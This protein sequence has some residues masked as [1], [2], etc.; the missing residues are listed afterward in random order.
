MYKFYKIEFPKKRREKI[1]G[2]NF[3]L[4]SSL[5]PRVFPVFLHAIQHS[6]RN[7]Q[8]SCAKKTILHT[9]LILLQEISKKYHNY[10]AHPMHTDRRHPPTSVPHASKHSTWQNQAPGPLQYMQASSNS[11][12]QK[13]H[14]KQQPAST[15]TPQAHSYRILQ[16]EIGFFQIGS[17]IAYHCNT[18]R[19]V[20][21]NLLLL[22]LRIILQEI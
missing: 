3:N 7:I 20:C 8:S 10:K 19:S 9:E 2:E 22:A 6:T 4:H 18:T 11:R 5:N 1:Q 16:G 21:S 14:S 13:Q 17:S 12:W 15:H